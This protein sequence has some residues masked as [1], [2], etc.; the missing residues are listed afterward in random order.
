LKS[1]KSEPRHIGSSPPEKGGFGSGDVDGLGQSADARNATNKCVTGTRQSTSCR[2]FADFS[3]VS[4]S[5]VDASDVVGR[6]LK[7]GA[8][9]L[10]DL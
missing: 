7:N 9:Q 2:G 4:V 1:E 5:S 3:P 8:G 6:R 10:G